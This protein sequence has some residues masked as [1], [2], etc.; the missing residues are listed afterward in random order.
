MTKTSIT[1]FGHLT[2]KRE[3]QSQLVAVGCPFLA[4]PCPWIPKKWADSRGWRTARVSTPVLL[5]LGP[6]TP[7]SSPLEVE[8]SKR[9]KCL[10][11]KQLRAAKLPAVI[12]LPSWQ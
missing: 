2:Q 5:R 10:T 12:V 1:I 9:E 6:T 3:L 11:N 7:G 4:G 8:M